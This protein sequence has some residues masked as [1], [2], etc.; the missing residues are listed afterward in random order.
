MVSEGLMYFLGVQVPVTHQFSREKQHRNLMAIAH[1]RR[2]VGVDVK[3]I[4]AK[5]ARRG[6]GGKI[7]P[8]LLAQAA[9]RA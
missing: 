9:P 2:G 6:Q 1:F 8:H 5:E 4:D 3:H 7:A